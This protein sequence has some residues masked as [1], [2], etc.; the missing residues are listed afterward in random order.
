MSKQPKQSKRNRFP[1]GWDE[2]R[3]RRLIKHYERQS[4]ESAAA[5]DDRLFDQ[6]KHTVMRIPARLVPTVR[7]LLQKQAS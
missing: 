1:K 3:V 6:K 2:T 5:E 7:K 4:D